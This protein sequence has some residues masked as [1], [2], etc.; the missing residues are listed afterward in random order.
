M[1][2]EIRINDI[3]FFWVTGKVKKPGFYVMGQVISE[4]KVMSSDEYKEQDKIFEPSHEYA[5]RFPEDALF[6]KF[7]CRLIKDFS[8]TPIFKVQLIE[9]K[10]LKELSIIKRPFEGTNFRVTKE[11]WQELKRLYPILSDTA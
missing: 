9:N 2:D 3:M 4:A 5:E 7:K 11:Q 10:I 1:K 6:P 8:N